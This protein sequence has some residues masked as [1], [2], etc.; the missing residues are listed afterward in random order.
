M[1][2]N[3]DDLTEGDGF[4][5]DTLDFGE[6]E[7][8][9]APRPRP[10]SID[11]TV[12][13]AEDADLALVRFL[14]CDNAGAVRGKMT[15]LRTLAARMTSGIGLTVAM[16][17]MNML[18]HLQAVEGLG[19]VGEVR[20]VPDPASFVLLPYAEGQGAMMCDLMTLDGRPWGACPR[21]FLK[22]QIARLAEHDLQLQAAVEGEFLLAYDDDGRLVP[23]DEAL[24]FG[25]AAMNAAATY[26]SALVDALE[27]QGL[28]LE[29]YYPELGHGQQE[30][31]VQHAAALRAAD[32]AVTVRETVRGIAS[33][34]NLQASFAP[35]PLADQ[36]GNGAHIHFSLWD[37]SGEV[38][39]FYDPDGRYNLSPLGRQFIAGVL[40]H[41]AG[42]V[43][44]TCPTVN[45]YR[46]LQPRSWASA[47][48]CWGPDNR[49]AAVRVASPFR[50]AESTSVN[51]ELKAADGSCNP[52]LALGGLI[53]AGLDGIARALDPGDPVLVDPA[54]FSEQERERLGI[55]RLP[56]SL[57]EALDA[58]QRDTV[59]T[60]ALGPLL[61][62]SFTAVKRGEIADFAA[63]DEAFELRAH[64]HTF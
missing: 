7:Y 30:L 43:A 47:F 20:L 58:L 1:N 36:A 25:A 46:R 45:S 19:P 17:A 4:D 48:T 18:D 49:E 41:L 53:A 31:S 59:L 60:T 8:E 23:V 37:P 13:Q 14:W 62:A 3:T 33:L 10:T 40:A 44:L 11:E 22:R 64:A 29:Q 34:H 16:Q 56:A 35:K 42:L 51:A 63:Q 28:A 6:L 2:G 26:V 5:V 55:H 32:D 9:D 50:G 57:G 15:G 27:R 38:N 52:Y 24:C 39:T 12:E 54:A 61:L 21:S